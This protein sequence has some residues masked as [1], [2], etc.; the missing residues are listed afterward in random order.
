MVNNKLVM[1]V[2]LGRI[3]TLAG[4]RMLPVRTVFPRKM[5]KQEQYVV[6]VQPKVMETGVVKVAQ[7]VMVRTV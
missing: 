5:P 3:V 6:P 1:L 2:M 7:N 4:V